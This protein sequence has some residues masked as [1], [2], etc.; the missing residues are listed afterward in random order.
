MSAAIAAADRFAVGHGHG[1]IHHFHRF[2]WLRRSFGLGS[3]RLAAGAPALALPR[4]QAV[5]S[6][7]TLQADGLVGLGRDA[8][9][10]RRRS[11]RLTPAARKAIARGRPYWERAHARFGR[12]YGD[13]AALSELRST[14]RNIAE[15]PALSDAFGPPAAKRAQ[16]GR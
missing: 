8:R 12:F 1:P 9:D 6:S 2:Y 15:N 3:T 13:A 11:V 4:N 7:R 5:L 10:S 16:R 14:L